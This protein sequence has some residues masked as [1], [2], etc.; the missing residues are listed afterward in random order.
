MCKENGKWMG[1][2]FCDDHL[3]EKRMVYVKKKNYTKDRMIKRHGN[4]NNPKWTCRVS[5]SP[6]QGKPQAM[7]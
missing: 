7:L 1:E 4:N 2:C 5:Q 6:G 3:V